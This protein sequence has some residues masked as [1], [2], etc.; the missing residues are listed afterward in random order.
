[1]RGLSGDQGVLIPQ[2]NVRHLMLRADVIEAVKCGQF[3][4]YP[5]SHVDQCLEILTGLPAGEPDENGEFPDGSVNH[6]IRQRLLG[7]ANQLQEFGKGGT[8]PED[9]SNA[10]ETI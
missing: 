3:H 6:K 1:M 7:F 8:S 4:V 2:A 9:D 10:C 5:V